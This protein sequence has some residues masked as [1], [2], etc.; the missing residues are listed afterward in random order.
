MPAPCARKLRCAFLP[1]LSGG[2]VGA[3]DD[4][5]QPHTAVHSSW[6]SS[7]YRI[8][9]RDKSRRCVLCYRSH[10][11]AVQRQTD[12]KVALSLK[13]L[14]VSKRS[15]SRNVARR[16]SSPRKARLI[17]EVFGLSAA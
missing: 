9:D 8:D 12:R 1:L 14:Q 6:E 4:G 10:R 11:A 16:K 7:S 3:V 13:K 2:G 17:D 15:G 5:S